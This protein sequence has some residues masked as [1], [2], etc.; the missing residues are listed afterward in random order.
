[1]HTIDLPKVLIADDDPLC[2]EALLILL[3]TEPM[4][5]APAFSGRE[6][7]SKIADWQPDIVLLDVGLPD[8]SGYEVCTRVKSDP[9]TRDTTI[10]FLTGM[11]ETRDEAHGLQL[12][13]VDYITKPVQLAILKARLKVH[14]ELKRKTRLL[15]TQAMLDSLTHVPNRRFFD[16]VLEQ[17]WNRCSRFGHTLSVMMIDIDF[18]KQYN[19]FYGH[20]EGD[21]C[22]QMVAELLQYGLKRSTDLLARFGGEEFIVLLPQSDSAEVLVMAEHLRATVE[23]ARIEHAAA[24]KP[25]VVTISI[26]CCSVQPQAGHSSRELIHRADKALY[27]AKHQ[28]RNK[29]VA[30]FLPAWAPEN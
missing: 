24:G 15:E 25:G 12:G 23:V 5:L 11:T 2:V 16:N 17:E 28:G 10:M 29:V 14:I 4:E 3:G 8:L 18:F 19:D 7:L 22:L 27:Q 9:A 21:N 6:A 1:M 30:E 26:G 13:A 20:L